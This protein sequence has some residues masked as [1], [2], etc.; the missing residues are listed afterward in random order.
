MQHW[1]GRN[2]FKLLVDRFLITSVKDPAVPGMSVQDIVVPI[3]D[4]D[5]LLRA[6]KCL[7][8]VVAV[9]AVGSVVGYTVPE[10]VRWRIRAVRFV[11]ATGNYTFSAIGLKVDSVEGYVQEISPSSGSGLWQPASP[12]LL[13]PGDQLIAYCDAHVVAGNTN[14]TIVYE[15]ELFS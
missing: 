12:V 15:E 1:I 9:G 4:A 8:Q 13:K 7:L 11:L 6:T 14:V 3:C 5:E 10:G 2:L